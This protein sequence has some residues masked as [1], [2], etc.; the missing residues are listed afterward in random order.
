M[1]AGPRRER[2]FTVALVCA[3]LVPYVG[4]LVFGYVFDDTA[5]IRGNR[6]IAG[7]S[8]LL[9]LW[10]KGYLD[11]DTGLYR[12]L[13]MLVFGILWNAG[14]HYPI[15]LHLFAISAHAVATV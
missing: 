3:A 2:W 1:S 8:S 10:T 11:A 13:T 5:A 14:G 7:W 6:A 15:W 12:P 4:T 9:T